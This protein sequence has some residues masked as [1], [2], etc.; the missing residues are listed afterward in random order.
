[1]DPTLTEDPARETPPWLLRILHPVLPVRRSAGMVVRGPASATGIRVRRHGPRP[2]RN[3]ASVLVAAAMSDGRVRSIEQIAQA[4]GVA[5]GTVQ[6]LFNK[7]T[8]SGQ[9]EIT[10]V[11]GRW[12]YGI[13]HFRG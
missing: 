12:L 6:K 9:V 2:K 5:E 1:M 11:A 7:L 8:A 13:T 4:A 10:I 3:T